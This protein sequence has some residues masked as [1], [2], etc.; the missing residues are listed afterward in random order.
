MGWMDLLTRVLPALLGAVVGALVAL[1]GAKR[2]DEKQQFDFA[3]VCFP[4]VERMVDRF[5]DKPVQ[6]REIENRID[7]LPLE[8]KV[9]KQTMLNLVRMVADVHETLPQGVSS[10]QAVAI[11][12]APEPAARHQP[13]GA[14]PARAPGGP[15]STAAALPS[16]DMAAAEPAGAPGPLSG[17]VA[18]GF[19]S[20]NAAYGDVNFVWATS[21]KP[22]TTAPQAGTVLR[23][24][25]QVNVRPKVGKWDV[26]SGVLDIGQCFEV[27]KSQ[28]VSV[29][30]LAQAWVKGKAVSCPAG[31]SR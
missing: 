11:A 10:A 14:P 9:N 8:C 12:A 1:W 29:A 27:E 30:S 24:K 25:W 19:V 21:G 26:V 6:I 16:P 5:Q 22:I 23:A 31:G 7:L 20:G 3:V 17:W 28:D 15:A 13:P 4:M 18:L 2:L